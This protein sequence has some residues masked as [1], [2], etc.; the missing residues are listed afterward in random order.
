MFAHYTTLTK[1]CKLLLKIICWQ[2]MQQMS[3]QI[4]VWN[5]QGCGRKENRRGHGGIVIWIF[6]HFYL[7]YS[8]HACVPVHAR[9]HICMCV[10]V[11]VCVCECEIQVVRPFLKLQNI[12]KANV[13]YEICLPILDAEYWMCFCFI[14]ELYVITSSV[15]R[16]KHIKN[17]NSRTFYTVLDPFSSECQ[18][19]NK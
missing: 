12:S 14:L 3:V 13:I 5:T 9:V 18:L 11:C 19:Q 16:E 7:G 6:K 4:Q 1:Q 10:C 2:M 17:P 15:P 8:Y